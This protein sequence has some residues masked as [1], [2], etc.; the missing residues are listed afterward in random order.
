ME[1]ANF[2]TKF[3]SKV[4]IVH[5]RDELRASKIMQERARQNP[6]ISWALSKESTEIIADDRGVTGLRVK[7]IKQ[8]MKKSSRPTEFLLRRVIRPIRHF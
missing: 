6:K 2:L 7:D 3:A 8:E 5:R 4:T 1:E